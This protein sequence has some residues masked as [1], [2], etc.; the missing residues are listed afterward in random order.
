M[1]IIKCSEKQQINLRKNQTNLYTIDGKVGGGV[2]GDEEVGD[3]DHDP[4]ARSPRLRPVSYCRNVSI[5]WK[6]ILH[7]RIL[8]LTL[9]DGDDGDKGDHDDDEDGDD[10]DKEDVTKGW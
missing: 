9:L 7:N 6:D 5:L 3:G 4:Q 8:K 1:S 10:G 2:G